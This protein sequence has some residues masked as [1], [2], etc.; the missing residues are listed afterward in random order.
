MKVLPISELSV[1][2]VFD[3]PIFLDPYHILTRT[4]DS[5][6]KENLEELKKWGISDVF[7]N[8]ENVLNKTSLKKTSPTFQLSNKNIAISQQEKACLLL[9]VKKKYE[10]FQ[11]NFPDFVTTLKQSSL[12]LEKHF[13]HFFK[14]KVLEVDFIQK[15]IQLLLEKV[16]DQPMNIFITQYINFSSNWI[17]THSIH[18]MLYSIVLAKALNYSRK[19]IE[20]L[21]IAIILMDIGMYAIPISIRQK[22]KPLDPHEI[23]LLKSHPIFSFRLLNTSNE[24]RDLI[25]KLAIEH[26][27]YYDGSGYPNGLKGDAIAQNSMI[28]SICDS[29]TAMIEKRPY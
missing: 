26:H 25:T 8:G 14:K 19:Q 24:L 28:A 18:T 22:T 17:L 5:I 2:T 13:L 9:E 27:E 6:T 20:N 7:T 23:K 4:G 10:S 16:W 21:M 1:G 15:E 29:Y 12:H 3:E 11:A